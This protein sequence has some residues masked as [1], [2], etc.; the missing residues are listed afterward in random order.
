MKNPRKRP[1][2]ADVALLAGVGIATV[3]R[4]LT[5]RRK[6]REE[7]VRLFLRRLLRLVIMLRRLF[8][9]GCYKMLRV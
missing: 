9:T 1:T 2:M 6:V 5:G 7:N 8:V 3:D 4:V